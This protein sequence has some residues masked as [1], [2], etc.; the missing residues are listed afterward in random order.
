[1]RTFFHTLL[2]F[3][4]AAIPTSQAI[5][6]TKD[7]LAGVRPM[8]GDG[9]VLPNSKLLPLPQLPKGFLDGTSGTIDPQVA[10]TY[11]L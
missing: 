5:N 1:M 6:Q 9:R 4:T 7:L 3:A 10:P 2:A 8:S 11:T